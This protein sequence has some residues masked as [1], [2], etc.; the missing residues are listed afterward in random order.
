MSVVV[1]VVIIVGTKIA[2]SQ[3]LA[4]VR[5]VIIVGAFMRMYSCNI[6]SGNCLG[7]RAILAPLQFKPLSLIL[8][9]HTL[10]VHVCVCVCVFVF[11]HVCVCVCV[12]GMGWGWR[13]IGKDNWFKN[14][15]CRLLSEATY[16][17]LN[18]LSA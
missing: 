4:H 8:I 3:D 12:G 13:G 7:D 1:V 5:G 9:L 10:C 17:Y 2:R 14:A 11:V 6:K 18:P 15:F 16:M